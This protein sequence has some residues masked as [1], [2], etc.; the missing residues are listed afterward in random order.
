MNET[1]V[2]IAERRAR[3]RP[4]LRSVLHL[5]LYLVLLAGAPARAE[6]EPK[7]EPPEDAYADGARAADAPPK[8][9]LARNVVGRVGDPYLRF[10]VDVSNAARTLPFTLANL[11]FQG[12]RL[13]ARVGLGQ[14]FVALRT[15]VGLTWALD[16]RRRHHLVLTGGREFAGFTDYDY[17]YDF[18]GLGLERRHRRWFVQLSLLGGSLLR[19]ESSGGV[20]S[21]ARDETVDT[22]SVLL[23][24]G[25]VFWKP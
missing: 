2:R 16:E 23:S 1:F 11:G 24:F 3:P 20:P 17:W 19:R 9:W 25:M 8:S 22:T 5:A 6:P 4:P 7:P 21:D 18:V 12:E 13:G 14:L 10:G 15:S